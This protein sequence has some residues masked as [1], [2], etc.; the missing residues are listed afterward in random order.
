MFVVVV[1]IYGHQ[2]EQIDRTCTEIINGKMN[3][4]DRSETV[5]TFIKADYAC[6][7]TI[8]GFPIVCGGFSHKHARSTTSFGS[9]SN[10]L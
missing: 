1:G 9:K 3:E 8:S 2:P 5:Q 6:W 10:F 7:C 4:V